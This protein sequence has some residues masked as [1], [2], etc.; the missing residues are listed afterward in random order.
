MRTLMRVQIPT[1]I[2]NKAIKD[3]TLSKVVQKTLESVKAAAA[4]FTTIDG[5][6]TMIAVFDLK[7]ASDMPRIAEP[8]F[9]GLNASVDFTP[10]MNADDLKTGLSSLT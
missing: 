7:A 10:C 8:L 6:R 1:D 2:G 4:Y 9:M 5:H 3:G